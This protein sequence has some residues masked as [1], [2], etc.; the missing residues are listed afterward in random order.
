MLFS[1]TTD[2]MQITDSKSMAVAIQTVGLSAPMHIVSLTVKSFLMT[3]V[4]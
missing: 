2:R 1:A 3:Q 4:N